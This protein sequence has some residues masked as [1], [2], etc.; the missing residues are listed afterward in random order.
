[1][2]TATATWLWPGLAF[3]P[4]ATTSAQRMHEKQAAG[5]GV[6]EWG[7]ESKELKET[8]KCFRVFIMADKAA[9][10]SQQQ[11]R[12]Q[13][14]NHK[15][16]KS[17]QATPTTTNNNKNANH[18][19]WLKYTATKTQSLQNIYTKQKSKKKIR[20]TTKSPEASLKKKAKFIEF[21]SIWEHKT[22]QLL[23]QTMYI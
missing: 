12:Q 18:S 21:F 10:I 3:C 16:I 2:A 20:K 1:M 19:W 6:R 13:Q 22:E 9:Q 4:A 15:A 5:R 23:A 8:W 11:Q 14:Q 7:E 17:Y